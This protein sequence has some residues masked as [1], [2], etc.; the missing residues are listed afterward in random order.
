VSIWKPLLEIIGQVVDRVLPDTVDA[1]ERLKAQAEAKALF[2]ELALKE[3]E[4]FRN[5]V[6]EHTGRAKDMPRPIQCLRSL[7]RPAVTIWSVYMLHH[8][9]WNMIEVPTILGHLILIVAIFWFGERAVT[10]A[11]PAVKDLLKKK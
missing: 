2:S 5:F 6:L 9:I 8:C 4:L 3:E 11:A 1:N 7:I 10:N